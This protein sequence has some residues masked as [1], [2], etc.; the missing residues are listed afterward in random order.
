MALSI[1]DVSHPD[2]FEK[3]FPHD[4]FCELR[5]DAPVYWHEGDY[6]GGRG[7]WIVSRYE[8]IKTISRQPLLF[9]S[10]SGSSFED[11]RGGFVSMIAVA[12]LFSKSRDQVV[13]S[14]FVVRGEVRFG[15]GFSLVPENSLE[16]A[17]FERLVRPDQHVIPG[18]RLG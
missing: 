11:D 1:P 7:Y 16:G 10:A 13:Q 5:R 15:I 2:S 9:S 4:V 17:R 6:Q 14:F 18:M 8:P 3:G 12:W